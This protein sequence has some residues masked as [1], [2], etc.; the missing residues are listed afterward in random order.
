MLMPSFWQDKGPPPP[1]AGDRR[2]IEAWEA[3]DADPKF[4]K[5]GPEPQQKADERRAGRSIRLAAILF[6][7][8][9]WG[10]LGAIA[11]S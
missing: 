11:L 9:F 3:P 10:A 5:T 6:C 1:L 8:V 7:L 4:G 2:R